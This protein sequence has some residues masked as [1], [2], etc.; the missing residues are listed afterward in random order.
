MSLIE[1]QFCGKPVVATDVGGVKDIVIDN[2]TGFLVKAGDAA[3]LAGRL[4]LL[5]ENEG[6]R[7]EMGMKA[8]AFAEENFSKQKEVENYKQLYQNLLTPKNMRH[9]EPQHA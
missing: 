4:K 9:S 5:I 3:A 8:E 6:L 7:K 2:E 1:A